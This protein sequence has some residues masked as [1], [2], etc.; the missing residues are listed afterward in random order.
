MSATLLLRVHSC[1][2]VSWQFSWKITA[3]SPWKAQKTATCPTTVLCKCRNFLVKAIN[4]KNC[5]YK[6]KESYTFHLNLF[7]ILSRMDT[8]FYLQLP[9]SQNGPWNYYEAQMRKGLLNQ[10][11]NTNHKLNISIT[12]LKD[13][14]KCSNNIFVIYWLLLKCTLCS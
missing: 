7:F 1:S 2:G 11:Q 8:I 5:L 10:K 6:I 12:P 4:H 13:H 3:K 14:F 9:L